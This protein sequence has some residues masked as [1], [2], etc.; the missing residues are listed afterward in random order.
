MNDV[1]ERITTSSGNTTAYVGV[2]QKEVKMKDDLDDVFPGEESTFTKS[3]ANNEGDTLR[4]RLNPDREIRSFKL[5]LM[6]AYEK[7]EFFKD[8]IGEEKTRVVFKRM[9]NFQPFINKQGIE[10]VTDYLK[11]LVNAHT[12][13]S[14]FLTKEDYNQTCKF[15]FNMM[16]ADFISKRRAWGLD[17]QPMSLIN[18]RF[19]YTKAKNIAKIG[20]RRALMDAERT[21]LGETV[22]ETIQTNRTPP[23]KENLLQK[24]AG[25]LK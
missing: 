22:K 13:Q 10:E 17:G 4:E 6:G 12:F 16:A 15:T 7:K 18:V 1:R 3:P 5:S 20:L 9:K 19:V 14:N 8:D 23:Q 11:N 25:I 21:H 2:K 24:A